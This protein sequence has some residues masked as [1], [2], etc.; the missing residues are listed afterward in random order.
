MMTVTVRSFISPVKLFEGFELG[1]PFEFQVPVSSTLGDL[2]KEVLA[3]NMKAIGVMAVN[4]EVAHEEY[5]LSLGDK[6]D[7]YP[8]LE[9]G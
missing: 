9:G 3:E 7:I 8:L 2:V 4:G 1:K 6:I 5:N